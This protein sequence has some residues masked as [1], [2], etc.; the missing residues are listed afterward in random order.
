M[1]EHV[2]RWRAD[3]LVFE[4]EGE[5][6]ADAVLE[7]GVTTLH[8][9]GRAKRNPSDFE[10]EGIGEELAAGRALIDLGHRLVGLTEQDIEAIEGRPVHLSEK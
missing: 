9:A 1:D 7:T 10:V 5:T 3:I 6:V 8:G 2:R 4:D